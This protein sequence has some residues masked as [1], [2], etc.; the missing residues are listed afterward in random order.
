MELATCRPV[1]M[2]VGE[3]PYTAIREYAAEEGV[4]DRHRF[5]TLIRYMDRMILARYRE[6]R[7]G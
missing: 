6:G 1:G 5:R 3:I 2:G 7:D 4:R